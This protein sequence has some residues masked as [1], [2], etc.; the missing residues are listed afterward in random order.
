MSVNV[1]K[2]IEGTISAKQKLTG[3]VGNRVSITGTVNVGGTSRAAEYDG[4]YEVTPTTEAQVLKTKQKLLKEDVVVA[5]IPKEY[6]L[7]TYNQDKT[8]TIT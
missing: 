5:A 7:V 6:G 3:T 4:V 8:I 2:K 1:K